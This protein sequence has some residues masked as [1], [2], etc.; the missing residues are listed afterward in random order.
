MDN[1]V[2][3]GH[4]SMV[5]VLHRSIPE[6]GMQC[7]FLPPPMVP[8]Q[9]SIAVWLQQAHLGGGSLDLGLPMHLH[10]VVC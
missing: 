8:R 1:V 6:G 3:C 7:H 5:P 4:R 9:P 2:G 10:V